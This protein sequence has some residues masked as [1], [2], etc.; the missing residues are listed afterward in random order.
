MFILFCLLWAVAGIMAL[1]LVLD[2]LA[3]KIV[4]FKYRKEI[5]KYGIKF[6]Y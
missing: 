2:S 6:D 1:Y 5:K 3:E 4:R